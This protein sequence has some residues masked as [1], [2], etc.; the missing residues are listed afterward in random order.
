MPAAHSTRHGRA[1]IRRAVIVGSV[2]F[3]FTV[4]MLASG[5]QEA[6]TFRPDSL[7]APATAEPMPT[8]A[9]AGTG[10]P[11][12][13]EIDPAGAAIAQTLGMILLVL[14]GAAL[15]ALLILI[16]RA[17]IR[18]WRNRPLGRRDAAD[19]ASEF[20][21]IDAAPDSDAAA[22]VIQRGI[23]G[24]LQSIDDRADPS[25]AIVAAWVGLEETAADAGV[26]RDASETPGEFALRII[27]LRSGVADEAARLLVLYE[28]VRFGA[29]IASERDRESAKQALRRIEGV[30]R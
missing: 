7:F 13:V 19:V 30:W 2:V 20:G 4:A 5:L 22:P 12:D 28:R 17:L 23:L 25:D 6:P 8:V 15:I 21:E 16:V 3:L 24:A 1:S 18:A 29:H 9:P 26:R 11:E 10:L 14:V 27:T